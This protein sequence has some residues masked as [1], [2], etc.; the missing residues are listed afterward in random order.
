MYSVCTSGLGRI[1][2]TTTDAYL[3]TVRQCLE[4]AWE[5]IHISVWTVATFNYLFAAAYIVGAITTAVCLLTIDHFE[6]LGLRQ[7]W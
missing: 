4:Y 5:R 1:L 3:P 7:V 6:F 2:S